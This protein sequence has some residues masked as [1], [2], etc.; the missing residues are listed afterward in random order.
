MSDFVLP[1]TLAFQL[2]GFGHPVHLV[3]SSGKKVGTFVPAIDLS[4]YEV[5]GP[6]PT[7]EDLRAA[8]E[9]TEWFTTEQVLRHL[10]GLK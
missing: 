9:S 2:Q 6:E 3:D 1:D 10:E 5:V 7:E 4:Q 8:E